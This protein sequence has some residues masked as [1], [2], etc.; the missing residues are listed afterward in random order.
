MYVT[1][2]VC[3]ILYP[4]YMQVFIEKKGVQSHKQM[5]SKAQEIEFT[6]ICYIYI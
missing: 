3:V 2:S 4:F 1:S 6:L 5:N